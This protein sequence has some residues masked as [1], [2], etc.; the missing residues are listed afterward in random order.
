MR[1][2]GVFGVD[3]GSANTRIALSHVRV[4]TTS[5]FNIHRRNSARRIQT[6]NYST[7]MTRW[8]LFIKLYSLL[9]VG[10]NLVR[11][12]M[13]F[14]QDIKYASFQFT[15]PKAIPIVI[16]HYAFHTIASKNP[17]PRPKL[18]E[19]LASHVSTNSTRAYT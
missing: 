4:R 5:E 2:G 8:V 15:K 14:C 19:N 10:R 16:N 9:Q 1:D 12:E 7:T 17:I 3:V 6:P 13:G 11:V 18:D